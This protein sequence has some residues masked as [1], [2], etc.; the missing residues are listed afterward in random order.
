MVSTGLVG[1]SKVLLYD[2]I[3]HKEMKMLSQGPALK[4]KT[5]TRLFLLSCP[6]YLQIQ[7]WVDLLECYQVGGWVFADHLNGQE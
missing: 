5:L 4:Q 2:D 6:S 3:A 7:T 1:P